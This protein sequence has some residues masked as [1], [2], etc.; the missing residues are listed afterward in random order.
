MPKTLVHL[1]HDPLVLRVE[2]R[3]RGELGTE[4]YRTVAEIPLARGRNE[5]D[6]DLW[7][8]WT[9]ANEGTP[10]MGVLREEKAEGNTDGDPEEKR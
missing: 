4:S 3:V 8:R 7:A 6:A 1:D 5:V 2:E 10:L 9:K